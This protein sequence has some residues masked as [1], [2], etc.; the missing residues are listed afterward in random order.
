MGRYPAT[1][2]AGVNAADPQPIDSGAWLRRLQSVTTAAEVVPVMEEVCAALGYAHFWL[3]L[4]VPSSIQRPDIYFLHNG[5]APWHQ[6]YIDARGFARDPLLLAALAQSTP[7]HW[8]G[9]GVVG[10]ETPG[11]L[12]WRRI[13][14]AAHRLL[15]EGIGV[16]WHGPHGQVGVCALS[17]ATPLA[18]ERVLSQ[19]ALLTGLASHALAVMAKVGV[20]VADGTLSAREQEV[21]L[22]AAE[23]KQA[24]DI[25]TILGITARTVTFHLM[26]VAD[27]L[28]A[29]SNSQAIAW[30]LKQ[31]RVTL[32][33]GNAKLCGLRQPAQGRQARAH[34][35]ALAQR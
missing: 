1:S 32:N 35:K 33:V 8:V 3:T 24:S 30:A 6:Q 21:C 11:D 26:R 2:G 13:D 20:P 17:C 27:K 28:R 31:G 34:I 22:W 4:V 16:P 14:C 18:P 19:L 9:D 5:P 29:N 25:A 23:G 10:G 12:G 7:I 15:G